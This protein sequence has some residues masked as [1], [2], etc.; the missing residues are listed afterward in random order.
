[1]AGAAWGQDAPRPDCAGA[2]T[3]IERT[4]C[5]SAELSAADRKMRAAYAS[6]VGRLSG[7]AKDHL[8]SDQTRWLANRNG[9]CIGE[10]A[11]IADCLETRYRDRTARLEWLG[12]G[13][14]P[15]ISEQAIVKTG[16]VRGIPYLIDA[17]YPQFDGAG[18]DFGAVNRQLAA[19]A[20]EGADRAVPGPDADNGGGNYNGP[21]W[22]YA[23]AYTLHRPGPNAIS[24]H[25]RYDSYEGGTQGVVGV[26][27]VLV[28]LRSGAAIGPESVFLPGSN[29]L[30]D[31]NRIAGADINA[32]NLADLLKEPGRYIFLEERLEL[33]FNQHEGGP[34][35]VEIP[36]DRLRSLLRVTGPVPR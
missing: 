25:I 9:A 28:D 5:G 4:V 24:V 23:Q 36:Y 2:A 22:S 6:L 21:P 15:F 7:L 32:P 35:T 30:R 26:S 34:Y 18:P 14:Y 31:L 27:G 3:P 19:M 20:R 29:W 10:P 1:M 16:T 8:A 33:S 11:E 17:S 13:A 12:D